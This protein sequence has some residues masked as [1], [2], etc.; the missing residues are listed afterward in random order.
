MA[1]QAVLFDLDDTLLWDER[2]VKEA[3]EAV[4]RYAQERTG[5]D[6]EK[7]EASVR[8]EARALYE[9]Y[10]TY[11]FT[12]RIGINPF[13]GLWARFRE[14]E[15][16]EFRKLEALAPAYRRESWIRG[17]RGIGIEDE[18]LGEE[19]AERFPAE[20][21]ARPLVYDET[22]EVL[23]RLRGRYKLLLLTNGS[24]DLQREKLAGVPELAPYFDHIVISGEFGEGKPAASI[25][26]HALSL[27][28]IGP[29]A[30]VMVGDKLTTDILGANTVGMD[31]VWINRHGLK[32]SGEIEPACE[33]RSLRELPALLERL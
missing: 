25:F 2:S 14:G 24:P 28:G 19:L 6:P 18:R 12:Q 29:D 30:G 21:R 17:L 27:L 8:R 5:A 32:R 23:D 26:R 33:I 10:E 22:F 7:L 3:F 15:Q 1:K 9:S 13:E 4:C 20:R 11:P 16:E 31:S